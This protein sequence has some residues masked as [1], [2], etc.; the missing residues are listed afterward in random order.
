M[1]HV[2]G[3]SHASDIHSGWKD[4][5]NIESHFINSTLCYSIKTK[6]K[7]QTQEIST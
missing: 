2:I 5:S 1:I 4:C 6:S 3:D 7:H